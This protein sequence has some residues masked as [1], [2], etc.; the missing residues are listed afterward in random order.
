MVENKVKSK[1]DMLYPELEK[2]EIGGIHCLVDRIKFKHTIIVA[3]MLTRT[4]GFI[5][6]EKIHNSDQK[7]MV[8]Y[9]LMSM[10]HSPDDFYRFLESL[11][12][13]DSE[14]DRKKLSVY[15]KEDMT[16][17]EALDIA[18]KSLKQDYEEIRGWLKKVIVLTG[19]V[20][21]MDI[22]I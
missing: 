22:P 16:N 8:T 15:I 4:M 7:Q 19:T 20:E 18:D 11:L 1:L 21:K 2:V 5:D 14:E 17:D 10:V 3:R 9:L 6:W 13:C 12:I